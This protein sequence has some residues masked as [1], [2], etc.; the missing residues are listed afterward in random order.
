[1]EARNRTAG[2]SLAPRRG[3]TACRNRSLGAAYPTLTLQPT[4]GASA[5]SRCGWRARHRSGPSTLSASR[6][7][8]MAR[9]PMLRV[10]AIEIARGQLDA[11]MLSLSE[12][13]VETL[14]GMQRRC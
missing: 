14:N 13:Q 5:V 4:L 9:W 1:M 12:L 3:E 6:V 8:P 7:P 11:A 2:S 10:G